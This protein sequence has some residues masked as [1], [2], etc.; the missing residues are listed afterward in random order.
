MN[1]TVGFMTVSRQVHLVRRPDRVL[2]PEDFAL[3]EVELPALK[4]GQ[5]L[6]RNEYISVDPY[7][8]R[9]MNAGKNYTPPFELDAVMTGGA[10]GQVIEST[11]DAYAVGD[12][13][14]HEFGWR[15]VAVLHARFVSP[16]DVSKVSPSAY[17]GALGMPGLTAWSG[18]EVIG[19][20]KAGETVFVS[21]AAGAVGSMVV[22]IAKIRGCRVIGSTGSAEKAEWLRELGF[23]EVINYREAPVMDQLREV[24]PEGIDVYFDNVGYD[25]LEAALDMAN[26]H[27]RFV[28]CGSIADYNTE[29]AP[30][31]PNNLFWIVGRRILV[32]GFIVSDFY[33]MRPQF[34]EEAIEWVE[35][36]QLTYRE[37]IVEGLENSVG[38]MEGL[39]T[40]ANTGK[41]LVKM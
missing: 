5:V 31:G 38:A 6:V 16:I 28:M 24:A 40:G 33:D 39:F 15:D 1:G 41:M 23:D 17:L 7:M 30:P 37:T 34:L 35:S 2:A 8:R 20:P 11:D 12:W 26:E 10:V 18:L 27:A 22:Q 9:R 32:Q 3:V 21:G 13:V 29:Q 14:L 25:H 4:P 36:G 19:K